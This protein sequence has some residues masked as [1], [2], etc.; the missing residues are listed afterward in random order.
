MLAC[1][2]FFNSF[3]RLQVE[4]GAYKIT[5]NSLPFLIKKTCL[6]HEKFHINTIKS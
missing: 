4:K 3:M 5:K 1:F 6:L 2:F